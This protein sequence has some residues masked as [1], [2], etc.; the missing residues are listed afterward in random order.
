MRCVLYVLGYILLLSCSNSNTSTVRFAG[1]AQGTTY[2]ITYQNA[3]GDNYHQE[4]D[5][6]LKELDS[7]LSTYNPESI[8]SRINKND[9]SVIP[10][11]HFITVFTRSVEISERT[12]GLFDATVAPLV[13]AYGFGFTKRA[14]VDIAMIDSLLQYVGYKMI[15]MESGR[16]IKDK[17]ASMLDFNA[18]AQGYSVDVIA[19]FLEDRGV[20]DYLVELGG[21]VRAR[22]KKE[23]NTYWRIGID[24]P[25]ENTSDGRPLQAV[26]E[27]KDA[28]LATS[29]NYRKFYIQD[30]KKYAHIINPHTGRPATHNLL[31]ATVIANDCMTA[32]AYAT[33]FM[34]MGLDE[35]KKFL[36][37]NKDLGLQV[38]F[39]YDEGG[40]WKTYFS[41][42]MKMLI[43][44][45]R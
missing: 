33:A 29:G 38:Y 11:H 19:R 31:S 13:N 21:E 20:K 43:H 16:I 24:K 37:N 6:L 7:S 4:I 44:E 23:D 3:S 26:I 18:I 35:G 32:D 27:L 28:S 34:V 15:R 45:Q 40:K 12:D 8:I 14:G 1:P 10:D 25:Q 22:G 36:E 5:S 9:S 39:V 17:S 30:G 41:E 42:S 2:Q